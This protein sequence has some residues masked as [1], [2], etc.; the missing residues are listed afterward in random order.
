MNK[1]V[2]RAKT[3][4]FQN[5]PHSSNSALGPT[6]SGA[7]VASH[8]LTGKVT[9]KQVTESA[10]IVVIYFFLKFDVFIFGIFNSTRAEKPSSFLFFFGT[11]AAKL[12][13]HTSPLKGC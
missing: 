11:I 5:V 13:K 10:H 7:C 6:I 9:S 8:F 4:A 1:P 12:E 2:A 3:P